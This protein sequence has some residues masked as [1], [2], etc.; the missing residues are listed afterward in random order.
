MYHIF[1]IYLSVS[2]H[3]GCFHVLVIVNSADMNIGVHVP[4]WIRVSS[5]YIPM[6][7]IARP[8]GSSVFSF[9]GTSILFSLMAAPIYIPT[10]SVGGFPILH[11]LTN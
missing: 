7:E 11:I 5:R 4:L 1:F 10:N 3:L 8:Y 9:L 2:G 6:S